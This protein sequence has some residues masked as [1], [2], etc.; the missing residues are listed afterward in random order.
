MIRKPVALVTGAGR[1]IGRGIS[2]ELIRCGFEVAGNDIV[3]EPD[4]TRSGLF[5]VKK[6]AEEVGGTFFPVPGDAADLKDQD[7]II[8]TVLKKFTRFEV[9]VNNAG[10]AAEKR[11]DLLDTTPESYDRLM[12]VNARGPFFLSQKAARLM[13]GWVKADPTLKPC[14]IFI[15]SISAVVSSIQRAEYCVSKAALSQTSTLF[16]DRL[17]DAGINVYE[18]RPGIIATGM[19]APVQEKY[20][21]LIAEGLVPQKRWGFPEDVGKA[22]AALA[23]GDFS[24]ATGMVLELSG[25]MNIRR[26]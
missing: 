17:A 23:R 13:T 6:R 14:L 19:T 4:N 2:L 11:Q 12:A 10:I 26:F 21:K 25:G 24:Y 1:G 18:V 15:T 5:E 16:A 7:K 20:D 22:V 9:L 3:V 8:E